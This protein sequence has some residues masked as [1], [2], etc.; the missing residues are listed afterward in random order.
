M[1]VIAELTT[2]SRESGDNGDGVLAVEERTVRLYFLGVVM[3][4]VLEENPKPKSK[5]VERQIDGR[6]EWNLELELEMEITL[7]LV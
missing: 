1:T 3:V 5:C 2:I 7:T 6:E 4:L